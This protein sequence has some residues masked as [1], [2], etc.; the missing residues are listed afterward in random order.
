QAHQ[1]RRAARKGGGGHGMGRSRA[2]GDVAGTFSGSATDQERT[3]VHYAARCEGFRGRSHCVVTENRHSRWL[4]GRDSLRYRSPKREFLCTLG[5]DSD[6]K[7]LST[8]RQCWPENATIALLTNEVSYSRQCRGIG[9]V[10]GVPRGIRPNAVLLFR[11]AD[12]P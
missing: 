1:F 2:R 4:K 3:S 11:S 7:A 9:L 6:S 8:Q 5:I 12:L 10:I